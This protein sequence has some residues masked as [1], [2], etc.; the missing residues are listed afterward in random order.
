MLGATFIDPNSN[1]WQAVAQHEPG[2]DEY[3]LRITKEPVVRPNR[4]LTFH[5]QPDQEWISVVTD[6]DGLKHKSLIIEL[7]NGEIR[8]HTSL[9]SDYGKYERSWSG[10]IPIYHERTPTF[11]LDY[12][13][14]EPGKTI[15]WMRFED[16]SRPEQIKITLKESVPLPPLSIGSELGVLRVIGAAVDD[17]DDLKVKSSFEMTVQHPD[18]SS[19]VPD[20][21]P[22]G[23]HIFYL[24]AGYWDVIQARLGFPTV[25]ARMIPV[26][27]GEVTV[28]V[29][30]EEMKSIYQERPDTEVTNAFEMTNHAIEGEFGTLDFVLTP[31]SGDVIPT[32]ENSQISE[33][34]LMGEIVSI[35]PITTPPD[36]VLL[37]DS[38]GSM[39]AQMEQTLAT[40]RTF[41]GSLT[42]ETSIQVIDFDTTP[43]LLAGTSKQEVLASL[44]EV[45]AD[46][47]T[48]L[49]DSIL[50]GLSLLA[51]K[52][53][54]ILLVF[55][56]GVDANWDDTGPGSKATLPEVVAAVEGT[57]IPLYTIGFGPGH[58]KTVLEQLADV[59]TGK[60]YSAGDQDALNEVFQTI[61][62]SL[63]NTYHL[64]YQRPKKPMI[65]DVP[66]VCLMVD[67]SGSMDTSPEEA[68]G[69]NYRMQ[70]VKNILHDFVLNLPEQTLVQIGTFSWSS[71]IE[72]SLTLD[73]A[74]VLHAIGAF[75]AGGATD[76][77]G[78]IEL[79]LK[80]LNATPSTNK[81]LIYITDAAIEER[82]ARIDQM[83]L[84]FADTDIKTIWMGIGLEDEEEVFATV[85]EK[86]KGRYV[87]TEDHLVLAAVLDEVLQE[88][89]TAVDTT[90]SV[91]VKLS[92]LSTT[93]DGKLI[94]Y[95][96]AM[97][98]PYTKLASSNEVVGPQLYSYYGAGTPA[99]LE[100]MQAFGLLSA[101][102]QQPTGNTKKRFIPLEA[103]GANKAL[104]MQVTGATVSNV[105]AGLTAPDKQQFLSIDFVL[106]NILEPQE[107]AIDTKG[108]NHP[109]SWLGSAGAR[110]R[111]EFKVPDYL[112]PSLPSHLYLGW[113]NGS[114]CPVSKA[115]WITPNSCS[116]R[117]IRASLY[118]LMRLSPEPW[119]FS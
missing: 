80:T 98:V 48:C 107:V 40:A 82:D 30:P 108:N 53:R 27:S 89:K 119:S 4:T 6:S 24:P 15:W 92:T 95:F 87:V 112:I 1:L 54:P 76:T 91:E 96:G 49:Y 20:Q 99:G 52:P 70:K 115:S 25:T 111:T 68:E 14:Q 5:P 31:S 37:L 71:Q 50:Q 47:A 74:S 29:L 114:M 39:R 83:L 61:N 109:A 23:D 45:R 105:L 110:G 43:K 66:V 102:G 60:Y 51:D 79:S 64:V 73:K 56:D 12:V 100:E 116:R 103:R 84:D 16:E 18:F 21:T 106:E 88:V 19:P 35:E 46:G 86:T 10:W 44:A 55:T 58:D 17:L 26:N 33:A 118:T 34:G 9:D 75:Q 113:N 28:F 69:C 72:Q 90:E 13:A 57:Q 117:V 42:D 3:M 81:T 101:E 67:C 41:I 104:N 63:A 94:R 77:L 11:I 59:S 36:I 85:A 2:R 93:V 65:S 97:G 22:D 7:S 8:M 62:S 78:S 32:L 38:S